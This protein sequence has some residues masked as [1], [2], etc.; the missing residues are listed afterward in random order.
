MFLSA[1]LADAMVPGVI[2]K[3]YRRSGNGIV[4]GG[5]RGLRDCAVGAY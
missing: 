3:F 2:G 4:E 5:G 1:S